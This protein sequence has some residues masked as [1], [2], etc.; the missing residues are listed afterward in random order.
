ME[1]VVSCAHITDEA[2]FWEA[3]IDAAKLGGATNFGRN[4]DAFRDAIIGGGPG[5]PGKCV[6]RL[7][8]FEQLRAIDGGR[9]CMALEKLA[10][11]SSLVTIRFE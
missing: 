9:L 1:I 7:S 8:D 5:W 6:L 3:Y 10:S 11:E 2:A 4:M